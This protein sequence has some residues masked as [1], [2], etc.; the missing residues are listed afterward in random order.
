MRTVRY[1]E[2]LKLDYS[3]V[4]RITSAGQPFMVVADASLCE[5]IQKFLANES[6]LQNPHTPRKN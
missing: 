5:R 4:R 6:P 2:L 3:E 1:E